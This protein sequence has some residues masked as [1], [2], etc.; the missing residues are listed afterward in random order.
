MNCWSFV[1]LNLLFLI[2]NMN[3]LVMHHKQKLIR[4]GIIGC[5]NV[6]EKKSGP[7]FYQL[8]DS[9]LEAVMRRDELK[10]HHY[11]LRHN[12]PKYYTKATDL[13]EDAAVDA[14]YVATPPDSHAR[15]ALE[16]LAAGKPVY[17]EKPM[18][19]NHR[20][21]ME[22]IEASEKYDVP[23]YVAYYRR[24]LPYFLK[25]KDLIDSDTIGKV[26]YAY[27]RLEREITESDHHPGQI[28]R[29]N[30]SIS[31]GGY[32]VDLG[33]HQINMLQF[34]FG[35]VASHKS[36]VRNKAGIYEVED[37]VNVVLQHQ[38]GI[39][40]SCTWSFCAPAGRRVDEVE[41]VGEKGSLYFSV[42]DM[43]SIRVVAN[44]RVDSFEVAVE[45]VIQKPMI[46]RIN[47]AIRHG[48]DMKQ[49]LLEAASTTLLMQKI[50]QE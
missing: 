41:V 14:V 16:A 47:E 36:F 13:I 1:C 44:H 26:L 2:T 33:S 22:M 38:S 5:G 3:S 9:A 19:L 32:F 23:L 37:F 46:S 15:Y 34:L 21:C 6:T 11:A 4:W 12:V 42:F 28:W 31:G 29:L 50:L 10:A 8:P 20:Q 49:D 25:I 39:D 7:A 40:V 17:V 48:I 43:N 27:M 30:P 24:A 18:A 35:P 45:P